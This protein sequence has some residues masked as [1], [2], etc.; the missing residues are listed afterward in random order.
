M[1]KATHALKNSNNTDEYKL[2][3]NVSLLR[4]KLYEAIKGMSMQFKK[5]KGGRI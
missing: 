4:I 5:K 3:I 2:N 1:K